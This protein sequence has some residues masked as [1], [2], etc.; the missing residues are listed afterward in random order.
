MFEINFKCN[1]CGKTKYIGIADRCHIDTGEGHY[2]DTILSS[3]EVM[4]SRSSNATLSLRV[5]CKIEDTECEC[6]IEKDKLRDIQEMKQKLSEYGYSVIK[7]KE[8]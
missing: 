6:K 8:K 5:L 4:S 3:H 1:D 7:N 2:M